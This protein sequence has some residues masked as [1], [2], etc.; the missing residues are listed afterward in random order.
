MF[1]D[2]AKKYR[3]FLLPS[4]AADI[5]AGHSVPNFS[6]QLAFCPPSLRE[7]LG[8]PPFVLEVMKNDGIVHT[9]TAVNQSKTTTHNAFSEKLVHDLERGYSDKA[10]CDSENSGTRANY[11][12]KDLK[13]SMG[14]IRECDST[15]SKRTDFC[16]IQSKTEDFCESQSERTDFCDS[17][18]K[19][20]DFCES[21]N[22]RTDFCESQN[23]RTDTVC[24]L[25]STSRKRDLQKKAVDSCSMSS[26][27]S[28][29]K[30]K[31]VD[32][33]LEIKQTLSN[34]S[35]EG[36]VST[37]TKPEPSSKKKP[38]SKWFSPPKSIFTKFLKV[39]VI[40]HGQ[41]AICIIKAKLGNLKLSYSKLSNSIYIL[42]KVSSCTCMIGC[43]RLRHAS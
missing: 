25:I 32:K 2:H 16:G 19:T 38:A 28:D 30:Q 36:K 26:A 12:D 34:G 40:R 31:K 18:S 24:P 1:D 5:L 14:E 15:E 42:M 41:L 10:P 39:S 4:E 11:C 7:T 6:S 29:S 17:Q 35:D 27:C 33:T 13:P 8:L 37:C 22:K 43:R 23:K 9:P 21:Q 20:E 3:W